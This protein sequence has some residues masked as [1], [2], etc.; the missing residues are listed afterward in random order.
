[1]FRKEVLSMKRRTSL[2]ALII[3]TILFS[4]GCGSQWDKT[5]KVKEFKVSEDKV[6]SYKK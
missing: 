6:L 5:L 1:M 2:A 3:I 4:S